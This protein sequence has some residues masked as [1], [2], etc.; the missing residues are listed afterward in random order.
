[1][2][3]IDSS[4]SS[5]LRSRLLGSAERKLERK[6]ERERRRGG[7]GGRRIGAEENPPRPPSGPED[8]T[9]M[10]WILT[11]KQCVCSLLVCLCVC[12]RQRKEGAKKTLNHSISIIE[13]LSG[14]CDLTAVNFHPGPSL[15]F[16]LLPT[17]LQLQLVQLW[18]KTPHLLSEPP[19][20]PTPQ[21]PSVAQTASLPLFN[22]LAAASSSQGPRSA[23]CPTGGMLGEANDS[24]WCDY[25]HT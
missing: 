21:A 8:S 14:G 5:S 16:F 4:H 13:I 18:T 10:R 22:F 11:Q 23:H 12:C 17:F 3:Q 1:M 9:L 19:H 6:R 7:E 20:P 2:P 25:S 24:Y 15:L